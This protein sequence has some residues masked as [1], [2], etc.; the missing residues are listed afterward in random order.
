MQPTA[1]FQTVSSGRPGDPDPGQPGDPGVMPLLV[2]GL[3]LARKV[4]MQGR[5]TDP[6]ITAPKALGPFALDG[7]PVQAAQDG[8]LTLSADA[9]QIIAFFC[10][11]VPKCPD[12]DAKAFRTK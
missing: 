5:I 6:A 8:T 11:P 10:T 3:L 12:P 7:R 1:P 9:P 4:R 2:T